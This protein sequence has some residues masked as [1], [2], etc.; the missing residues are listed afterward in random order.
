MVSLFLAIVIASPAPAPTPVLKT[1]IT[2]KSSPFCG[3][4][5][6]H[7]NAAIGSAVENDESLAAVITGLRSNALAGSSL[8]RSNELQRL[9]ALAT[10]I[11]KQYRSGEEEVQ[12]LRVLASKTTDP[13]EKL[14]VDASADALGGALYRQHLVQRDLDGF[15]SYLYASDMAS[16]DGDDWQTPN[17][18]FSSYSALDRADPQTYWVPGGYRTPTTISGGRA[19]WNEDLRMAQDAAGDF[20][21]RMPAIF[22]DELT[23]GARIEE[24]GNNC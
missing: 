15:V 5:A 7:V 21:D 20:Q 11:Y 9:S 13:Q 6:A 10:A 19:S 4:L 12:R 2:V 17:P 18:G 3:S 16:N 22:Q 14:A 1:I 24:A 8:Q 23:A